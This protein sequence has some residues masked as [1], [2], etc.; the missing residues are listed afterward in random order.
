MNWSAQQ[1]RLLQALGY[2]VLVPGRPEATPAAT[3]AASA[4]AVRAASDRPARAP[5]DA[6]PAV[7]ARLIEALRRAAG[8]A[9]PL[10]LVD[11][12]DRLRREPALKRALW[13]R[14]RALRRSRP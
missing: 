7:P 10:A 3:S 12:L 1:H 8:G 11:D 13:P 5:A 6:K 2:E 14:L 9:D 4:P